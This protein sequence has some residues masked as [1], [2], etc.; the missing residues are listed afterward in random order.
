M[1][2]ELK[3]LHRLGGMV[4]DARLMKLRQI[5]VAEREKAVEI[6]ALRS[7]ALA[8]AKILARNDGSDAAL[9]SGADERWAGWRENEMRRLNQERAVLRVQIEE[10]H[11]AAKLA[12]GRTETLKELVQKAQQDTQLKARRAY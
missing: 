10:Q 9:T 12:F 5:L 11:A 1:N 7:A 2:K 8:R 4:L 6:N 3:Q